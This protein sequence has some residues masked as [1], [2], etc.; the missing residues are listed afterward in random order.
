MTFVNPFQTPDGRVVAHPPFEFQAPN[1]QYY[2][3]QASLLPPPAPQREV[4]RSY[5]PDQPYGLLSTPAPTNYPAIAAYNA[6]MASANPQPGLLD[7]SVEAIAN[8]YAQQA[9]DKAF[10]GISTIDSIKGFLSDPVQ[11]FNNVMNDPLTMPTTILGMAMPGL[12]LG[13][14]ALAALNEEQLAYQQAMAEMG[15]KG[16][17][18]GNIAGQAYGISPTSIG[19]RVLSGVVPSW[20]DINMHD[21][22]M[23]HQNNIMAG[24]IEITDPSGRA[25][26]N[27]KGEYVDAYNNKHAAGTMEDAQNLANNNNLSLSQARDALNAA[28]RGEVNLTERLQKLNR[29]DYTGLEEETIDFSSMLGDP[30]GLQGNESQADADHDEDTGFGESSEW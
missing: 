27:Q 14:T 12:G 22:M 4:H 1:P 28:R 23:E 7:P 18:Y 30:T 11:S 20:F 29:T 25:G 15:V 26:Y 16:Y 13:A 3:Q 24:D 19:G 21:Q 10:P 5:S 6:R 9:V 8:S 2:R 17:E